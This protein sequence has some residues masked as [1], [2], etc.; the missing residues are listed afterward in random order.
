M[1]RPKERTYRLR[2]YEAMIDEA[3]RSP[4]ST[5][6]LKINGDQLIEVFHMK[7]GKKIG[8]ILNA[9]MG[10]T[11]ETPE[12]NNYDYLSKKVKEYL[13]LPEEEL[14]KLADVG[15]ETMKIKENAEIKAI[16]K[17]HKVA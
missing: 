7:P 2:Q 3:L 4:I 16:H 9:L 14:I 5:K 10:V 13:K 1:G 17:K 11:L 8:L 12:N 15:R 6:D